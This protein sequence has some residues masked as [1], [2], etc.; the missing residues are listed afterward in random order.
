MVGP[1][2][3]G[4]YWCGEF[5]PVP[6]PEKP[7]CEEPLSFDCLNNL[8]PRAINCILDAWRIRTGEVLSVS[9]VKLG[10]L[11]Q[12]SKYELMHTP[13]CGA[14]TVLEI[15]HALKNSVGFELKDR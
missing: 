5:Q 7:R 3:D 9:D 10:H 8:S 4:L 14:Q 6:L 1:K 13:K 11:M 2:V 15:M 12:L